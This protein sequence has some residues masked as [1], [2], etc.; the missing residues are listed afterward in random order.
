MQ[1][2]TQEQNAQQFTDDEVQNLREIF[3]LFDKEKTGQISARDLE[4]IM[5]SLQRDPEEVREFIDRL[6]DE[7]TISFDD[8]IA[9]MQSIE[10]KIVNA[11]NAPE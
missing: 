6:Q 10:S 9:L 1:Q 7:G 2:S 8:F 11:D 3:D 4:T 5:G